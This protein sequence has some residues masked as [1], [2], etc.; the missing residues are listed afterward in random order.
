MK[1][2][3]KLGIAVLAVFLFGLSTMNAQECASEIK[4]L[5]GGKIQAAFEKKNRP[6][7][8]KVDGTSDT[9]FVSN[10]GIWVS[11]AKYSTLEQ[12]LVLT[13]TDGSTTKSCSYDAKGQPKVAPPND[14]NAE[15]TNTSATGPTITWTVADESAVKEYRVVNELGE[16]VHTQPNE[17]NETYEY[18]VPRPGVYRIVAECFSGGTS[19]SDEIPVE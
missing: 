11:T 1:N 15:F 13:M 9:R 19:T 17:D 16:V 12:T 5:G 8:V 10:G 14:C 18:T 4:S 7:S 2:I 3:N 6:A